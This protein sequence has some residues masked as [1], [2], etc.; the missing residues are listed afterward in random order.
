MSVDDSELP[1]EWQYYC[2]RAAEAHQGRADHFGQGREEQ[3][4]E[5]LA[6][7]E[8]GEP[9][10]EACRRRLDRLPQN[11]AKKHQR[12][13]RKFH[14]MALATPPVV[15]DA[16]DAKELSEFVERHL[17]LWEWDVE[18]RLAVG[19]SFNEIADSLDMTVTALKMRASRWRKRMRRHFSNFDVIFG[20]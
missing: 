11:R 19:E 15:T 14:L 4:C 1:A 3:L 5:T 16:V 7:I 10:T 6:V 8:R 18:W 17:S 9:F 13:L 2:D 12:L 20:C